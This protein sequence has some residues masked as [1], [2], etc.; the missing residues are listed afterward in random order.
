VLTSSSHNNDV[1]Q[2]CKYG[3]LWME[4]LESF[5]FIKVISVLAWQLSLKLL[6]QANI[7]VLVFLNTT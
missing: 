6:Y 4:T 7:L 3:A 1:A 5:I 2:Q